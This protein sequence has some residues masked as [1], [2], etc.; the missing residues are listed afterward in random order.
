[1]FLFVFG[2]CGW[3]IRIWALL[4]RFKSFTMSRI[5]DGRSALLLPFHLMITC[6]CCKNRKWVLPSSVYISLYHIHT[7]PW[8]I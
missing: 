8:L 5:V 2:G 4:L 6:I 7:L 3:G 1:M